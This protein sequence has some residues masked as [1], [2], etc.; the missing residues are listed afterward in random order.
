L[1]DIYGQLAVADPAAHLKRI[2][3]WLREQPE[4]P[5]LLLAAGRACVRHQLWGKARSYLETSLAIR[6]VPAAY[7]VLGQLMGRVGENQSAA[8]A[9]EKGLAISV[10]PPKPAPAPPRTT[11][12]A[13]QD[14]TT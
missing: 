8:R 10:E 6:P 13:T 2:E 9:Y 5:V 12:P 1:L 14:P 7:H 4:N 11:L 3:A